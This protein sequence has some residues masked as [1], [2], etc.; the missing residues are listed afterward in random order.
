M[1]APHPSHQAAGAPRDDRGPEYLCLAAILAVGFWLRFYHLDTPSLWYDEILLPQS[2]AYPFHY[3]Y[4]W[5]TTLEVHPPYP[6]LLVKAITYF[7]DADFA[8]RLPLAAIGTA[9]IY[10]L[11]RFGKKT[12]PGLTPLWGAG[13]LAI[14]PL[15]VYISRVVRPYAFVVFFSLCGLFFLIEYLRSHERKYVYRLAAANAAMLLFHYNA[16]L[17]AG[18]AGLTLLLAACLRPTRRAWADLVRYAASLGL[19]SLPTLFFLAKAMSIRASGAGYRT[20]QSI[21]QQFLLGALPGQLDFHD[22]AH[23]FLLG[24]L[25][26]CGVGAAALPRQRDWGLVIGTALAAPLLFLIILRHG[27]YLSAWHVVFLL[28][29]V[30]V[31]MAFGGNTLTA[32]SRK[33]SLGTLVALLAGGATLYATALFKNYYEPASYNGYYK[34]WALRLPSTVRAGDA[35]L[36]DPMHY[37]AVNWYLTKF[38]AENPLLPEH[39]EP[40]QDVTL[41]VLTDQDGAIGHLYKTGQDAENALGRPE[42]VTELPGGRLSTYK[43]AR[44]PPPAIVNGVLDASLT[45][46]PQDFYPHVQAFDGVFIYPYWEKRVTPVQNRRLGSFDYTV[47]NTGAEGAQKI[48]ADIVY[49]NEGIGDRFQVDAIFDDEAPVPVVHSLQTMSLPENGPPARFAWR[50]DRYK[51]FAKLVLRFSL[52]ADLGTPRYNGGNLDTV[53]FERLRLT[54]APIRHDFFQPAALPWGT[55]T[56]NFMDVLHDAAAGADWRWA[57]GP[58]ATVVLDLPADADVDFSF[59]LNNPLPGQTVTLAANGR[60]LWKSGPLPAQKW[61]RERTEQ[62]VRFHGLAGKNELVF[63]FGRWNGSPEFFAPNDKT[64]YAAA[65]TRLDYRF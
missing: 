29:V 22:A 63:D 28:P 6:Y 9:S 18:A 45:A 32:S 48:E 1:T 3:F 41:R 8:L 54:A 7:S 65:F 35:V 16:V 20:W 40:G 24:G 38:T 4:A 27:Y 60:E 2:V 39:G 64:P 19:F 37:H 53:G 31:L 42:A 25:A 62:T 14:N 17:A 10:V 47:V 58:K 33:L 13:L 36:M 57:L 15:H 55:T 46:L 12:L 21:V 43:L 11:Y 30:V 26:L 49:R 44:K 34:G 61:L 23:V 51:P 56:T 5:L 52:W 59:A 50:F